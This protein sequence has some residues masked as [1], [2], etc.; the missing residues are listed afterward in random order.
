MTQIKTMDD[1]LALATQAGAQTSAGIDSIMALAKVAFGATRAKIVDKDNVADIYAAYLAAANQAD[2]AM[3]TADADAIKFGVSKLRVFVRLAAHKGS[4]QQVWDGV[5]GA[6]RTYCQKKG[7][8]GKK[9]GSIYEQVLKVARYSLSK[10]VATHKLSQAQIA[11]VFAKSENDNADEVADMLDAFVRKAT[12]ALDRED[13]ALLPERAFF[14]TQA[15]DAA[16]SQL[17][18]YK[19]KFVEP[20]DAEDDADFDVSEEIV[21]EMQ[22]AA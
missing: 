13:N 10:E 21:A 11:A 17:A 20:Q 2:F 22:A 12:K 7:E 5:V 4:A 9:V 16:K 1:A 6:T 19:E 15:R 3:R 18:A 14:L 8:A